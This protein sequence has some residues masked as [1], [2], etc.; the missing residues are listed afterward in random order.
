MQIATCWVFQNKEANDSEENTFQKPSTF[1]TPP[2]RDRDLN[3][4][5]HVLNNLDLEKIEKKIK[6]NLS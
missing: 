4:Q 2:N 3:Y 6:S 1:T 5:I